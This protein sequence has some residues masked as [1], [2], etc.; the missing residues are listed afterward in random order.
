M[1]QDSYKTGCVEFLPI[2]SVA[3]REFKTKYNL[4]EWHFVAQER[5]LARD[6]LKISVDTNPLTVLRPSLS[7]EGSEQP[8]QNNTE[9]SVDCEI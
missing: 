7:P 9:S 1:P 2:G 4:Q 6:L 8:L 5:Y 3:Y